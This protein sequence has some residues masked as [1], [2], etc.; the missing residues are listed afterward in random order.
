MNDKK[1]RYILIG[2]LAVILVIAIVIACV[3][4]GSQSGNGGN[5][6]NPSSTQGSADM[7]DIDIDVPFGADETPSAGEGSGTDKNPIQ[8]DHNEIDFDDLLDKG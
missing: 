1:K 3:L 6:D 4:I 7:N 5:M 8:G 2:I